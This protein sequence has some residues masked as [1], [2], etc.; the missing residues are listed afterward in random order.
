MLERTPTLKQQSPAQFATFQTNDEPS[1]IAARAARS[2][3]QFAAP[4]DVVAIIERAIREGIA[5]HALPP[6]EGEPVSRWWEFSKGYLT[7]FLCSTLT[8]GAGMVTML[9]VITRK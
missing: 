4:T 6:I 9:M 1:R 5:G 7:G 8:F 3:S 2:I